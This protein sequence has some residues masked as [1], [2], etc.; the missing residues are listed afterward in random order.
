MIR[1][2]IIDD[3]EDA[4]E[5]LAESI[6]GLGKNIAIVAEAGSVSSGIKAINSYKPDLVFLD[7]HLDDGNGFQVL[8]G[9]SK[10]DF[11]VIFTT[12]SGD[13]ALKAIKFSAVDYLLKPIDPDELEIAINKLEDKSGRDSKTNS[14]AIDM[15]IE[16][17]RNSG[18]SPRRVALSS[19]DRIHIVEIKDIV[20]CESQSNYTLFYLIDN[21]KIL[22]TRTL[23]EFEEM[24]ERDNF[25]RIHHSHL[26]NL[27]YLREYIKAEGGYA[28]MADNSKIP[29]AVRKK[30]ELLKQLGLH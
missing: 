17:M 6:L 21:R 22:V 24:F 1:A 16:N 4:R 7:I 10:N 3:S 13:F 25:I 15:L 5:T 20:R 27:N 29:V 11:K 23:K 19:A 18:Q 14:D 8:E 2:I 12:G 30:D 26:V 9:V 28:V